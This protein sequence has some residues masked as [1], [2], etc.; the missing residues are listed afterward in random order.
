MS[1]LHKLE[2]KKE[3]T[4]APEPWTKRIELVRHLRL[5]ENED[6]YTMKPLPDEKAQVAEPRRKGLYKEI[7]EVSTAISTYFK[8]IVEL[9][10]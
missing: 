1:T 3:E 9:D 10:Y 6:V 2:P 8:R 4:G 5:V 7:C